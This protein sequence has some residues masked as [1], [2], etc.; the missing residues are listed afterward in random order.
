MTFI[1]LLVIWAAGLLWFAT[2]I[3]FA[4]P[5]MAR[6]NEIT[7]AI[8]VLTGGSRRIEE[9]VYLLKKN[10]SDDLFISGV[11]PAVTE[12]DI[13]EQSKTQGICCI[14]LGF[15]ATNTR[16]N[17]YEFK[18]W[19]TGKNVQKTRVVTSNYHMPRAL[20]ELKHAMPKTE[21]YAHPVMPHEFNVWDKKFWPITFSE[22]NKTIL[23]W[24]SNKIA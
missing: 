20:I 15:E 4:K 18:K 6:G 24:L 11:N 19:A 8:V 3:S 13:L 2:N 10:H 21:F 16:E 23:V 14:T 5:D 9:G 1:T 17:A 7:D 22:Y 12:G